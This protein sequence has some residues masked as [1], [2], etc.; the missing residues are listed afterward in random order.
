MLSFAAVMVSGTSASAAT[1]IRGAEPFNT[2]RLLMT[3]CNGNTGTQDKLINIDTGEV[4]NHNNWN[5]I[6][7]K[8]ERVRGHCSYPKASSW[9]WTGP[10][11]TVSDEELVNCGTRSTLRQDITSSGSTTSTT[12]HSVSG[13]VGVNWTAIKD[14]LSFQAGAEYS[15]SWSY[16]KTRGWAKT[17]SLSVPPRAVGWMAQ[18]PKMRTVRSNP[19][20]HVESYTWNT[21]P[22]AK[23]TTVNSWRGR[24]YRDIKSHGAYYDAKANVTDSSGAPTG[25]IVARDRAVN[26]SDDC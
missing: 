14:V 21:L 1:N 26:S 23:W 5:D 25:Q 7:G 12:S 15:H 10:E 19:V 20:F 13:S 11:R 17:S 2:D 3:L 18:R 24:G 22:F 6:R 16:A 9:T 8:W 4:R